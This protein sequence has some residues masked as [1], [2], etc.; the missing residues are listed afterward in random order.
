MK[1]PHVQNIARQ[2]TKIVYGAS[3]YLAAQIG[4]TRQAL[5]HRIKQAQNST[6]YHAW[7]EFILCLPTGALTTGEITPEQIQTR[8]DPAAV[9]YALH[10]ADRAW[11]ER[12]WKR[13]P[14]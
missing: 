7:I 6:S 10:N 11:H 13:E 9:A 2:R 14:K 8:P 4:L 12:K 5:H 1:Y 3:S